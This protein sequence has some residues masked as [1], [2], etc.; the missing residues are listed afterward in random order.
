MSM[1]P[2]E[3]TA[4][5]GKLPAPRLTAVTVTTVIVA[6]A[7]FVVSATAVAVSVTVGGLGA[8]PG[9]VN[10][11]GVPDELVAAD[12]LPHEGPP[13]SEPERAQVT[14]L[15][16]G[17]P[18]T[19]AVK[20][21]V[22]FTATVDEVGAIETETPA[23]GEVIVIAAEADFVVSLTDVAV[24][25]TVG[26][27]GAV[28]GAVYVTAVPDMLDELESAP[29]AAPVQPIPDNTHVTPLF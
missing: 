16:E 10:V 6:L 13:H 29:H 14:P 17:W 19:V 26:G 2:L 20:V 4:A 8:V 1:T 11:I 25:V 3:S 21:V 5:E 7:N 18:V 12:K 27:F 22:A 9:A 24:S 23:G 28:A 15:F